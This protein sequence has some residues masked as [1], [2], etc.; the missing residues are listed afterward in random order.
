MRIS[1][2]SSD[3]CSSDLRFAHARE[4]KWTPAGSERSDS[5]SAAPWRWNWREAARMCAASSAFT[6]ALRPPGRR[7]PETSRDRKSVVEGK[8]VAVRGGLGGRRAI[9]KKSHRK[10][11]QDRTQERT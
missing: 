5:A 7:T 6:A 3:V 2:W 4:R 10:K 11:P 1:D 9:K 8:R